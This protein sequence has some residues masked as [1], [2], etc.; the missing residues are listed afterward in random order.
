MIWFQIQSY[1]DT[2]FQSMVERY[3]FFQSHAFLVQ[4]HQ[5]EGLG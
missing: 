5:Y 3:N 4:D 2:L 1:S